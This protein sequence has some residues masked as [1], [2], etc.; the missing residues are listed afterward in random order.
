M[1]GIRTPEPIDGAQDA[2][3]RGVRASSPRSRTGSS[4][5]TRTCRTSSSRSRRARST[6]CRPAPASASAAAAV[7]M[8]VEMVRGAA[9][10]PRHRA[11]AR[12]TPDLRCHQLARRRRWTPRATLHRARPRAAG[13]RRRPRWAR[14]SSTPTGRWS[15]AARDEE[16]IL[17]RAETSPE[18]VAGMYAAEGIVT[19]ARRPHVARG[20]GGRAAWGKACVVGAG[21]VVVDEER[22][23][24]PRRA[25]RWCARATSITLDGATGEVILGAL[26]TRRPRAVATSSRSSW[27]GP[28]RYRPRACGPTPTR[29]RTPLKA[30][31]F[32]AEG[33]GLVPHRAHVL[34]GRPHP[35]RA[36]DDH[37]RRRARRA[38]SRGGAAPA[39][40]AR[41]LHRHL[42]GDG[43]AAGDDPAARSAA[44]RV[45]ARS[46][47][48]CSRSTRGWT[49]AASTRRGSAE[50]GDDQGAAG[51][52]ARGQPDARAT[53]AAGSASR[54]PRSTTCRCGPS[55]RRPA[56]WPSRA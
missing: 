12:A 11:A 26:A 32:G 9:D 45:P 54:S 43:R 16:V 6:S 5:T 13:H 1:A 20:G 3:A 27:A 18:D 14:S 15:G 17:V 51:G 36:R 25:A 49:R 19:V 37:G 22:R 38:R 21:D 46:T 28:T 48:R 24:L 33:I 41:G 56:R 47:R 31:E 53:A 8:A 10:R 35:D 44:A 4:G 50:L 34:R 39:L 55:W 2:H 23:S 30:R 40:P 52:A 42:P 7:R 29:P